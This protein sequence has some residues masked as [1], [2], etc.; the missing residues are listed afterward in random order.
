[1]FPF[2]VLCTIRSQIS[3]NW[4]L[5]VHNISTCLIV[6][7]AVTSQGNFPRI[8]SSGHFPAANTRGLGAFFPCQDLFVKQLITYHSNALSMI[9]SLF[10]KIT[11]SSLPNWVVLCVNISFNIS[12]LK[13]GYTPASYYVMDFCISMS[14]LCSHMASQQCYFGFYNTFVI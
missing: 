7:H 1:M 12:H 13:Y 10:V 8:S 6:S 14:V 2:H 11:C 9:S 4:F 3:I 5:Q